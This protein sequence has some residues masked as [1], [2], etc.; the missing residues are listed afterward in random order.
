MKRVGLAAVVDIVID[1]AYVPDGN[2]GCR[3]RTTT[4]EPP[5]GVRPTG[6][7]ARTVHLYGHSSRDRDDRA[8]LE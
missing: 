2:A 1:A 5:A 8:S 6:G 7:V 4:H 3:E